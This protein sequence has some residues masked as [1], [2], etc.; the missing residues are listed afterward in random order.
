MASTQAIPAVFSAFGATRAEFEDRV[1][2][3]GQS[4]TFVSLILS[5]AGIDLTSGQRGF[6]QFVYGWGRGGYWQ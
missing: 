6:M 5:R 2:R 1:Y 3:L 4:N